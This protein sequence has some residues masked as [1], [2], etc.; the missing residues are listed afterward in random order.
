VPQVLSDFARYAYGLRAQRSRLLITGFGIPW[1][2]L[3]QLSLGSV[4]KGDGS[5]LLENDGPKS[6]NFRR[7]VFS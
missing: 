2:N 5:V 1:Q 3:E 6:F 7:D 4:S